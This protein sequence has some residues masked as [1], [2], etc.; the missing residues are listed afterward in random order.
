V[1]L[2]SSKSFEIPFIGYSHVPADGRGE[3]KKK[4]LLQHLV[5][6]VPKVDVRTE[7]NIRLF[8]IPQ[9]HQTG[10]RTCHYSNS[11]YSTE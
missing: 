2:P 1:E 3:E 7:F 8:S 6:D 4:A 11:R 5:A 10:Y 9:I